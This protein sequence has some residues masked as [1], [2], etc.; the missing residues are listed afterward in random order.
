M[1]YSGLCNHARDAYGQSFEALASLIIP[2]NKWWSTNDVL[3]ATENKKI[4][5]QKLAYETEL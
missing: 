5:R 1:D 3:Q 4:S 2:L